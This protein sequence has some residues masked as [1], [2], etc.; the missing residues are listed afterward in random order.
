MWK[1]VDVSTF[2]RIPYPIDL[3][4]M[5]QRSISLRSRFQS[6][7]ASS[8]NDRTKMNRWTLTQPSERLFIVKRPRFL[9]TN[10]QHRSHG[11][12]SQYLARTSQSPKLSPVGGSWSLLELMGIL[13]KFCLEGSQLS[14]ARHRTALVYCTQPYPT[15]SLTDHA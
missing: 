13:Y 12:R 4:I 11:A 14:R 3:A 8:H 10:T 15:K 9:I 5:Y 7:R 2:S 6:C 1:Q